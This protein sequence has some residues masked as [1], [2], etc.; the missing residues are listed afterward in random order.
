MPMDETDQPDV[1]LSGL[2]PVQIIVPKRLR[3]CAACVSSCKEG[4]DLVCRYD[5][6]QVTFLVVP[7]PVTMVPTPQGPRP[8]QAMQ[9]VPHTSFPIVRP[10]MWCGRF[11]QK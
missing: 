9:A 7:G 8:Q 2:Q 10:D 11:E 1:D 6:P 5:P 3:A 4:S